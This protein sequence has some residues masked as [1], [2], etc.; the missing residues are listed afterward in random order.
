M[1]GIIELTNFKKIKRYIST[2]GPLSSSPSVA[3][4]LIKFL[5]MVRMTFPCWLS[6]EMFSVRRSDKVQTGKADAKVV[7]KPTTDEC[8]HV[9]QT[10]GDDFQSSLS[11]SHNR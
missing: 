2:D 5:T 4:A 3:D 10:H 9:D 8:S 1:V 6:L 7:D 11:Y